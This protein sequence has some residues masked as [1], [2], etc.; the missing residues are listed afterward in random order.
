MQISNKV[1]DLAVNYVNPAGLV[2][3]KTVKESVNKLSQ[4]KVARKD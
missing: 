2:I 1:K 3:V 4:I